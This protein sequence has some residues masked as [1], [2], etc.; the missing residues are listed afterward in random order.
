MEP[1]IVIAIILG[2]LVVAIVIRSRFL[3]IGTP[4]DKLHI[5]DPACEVSD[6]SIRKSVVASAIR[7]SKS[8]SVKDVFFETE[9]VKAVPLGVPEEP[10]PETT[11]ISLGDPRKR[12]PSQLVW[13]GGK[14]EL[15][16]WF[17]VHNFLAEPVKLTD[18]KAH[19]YHVSMYVGDGKMIHAPNSSRSVE[20]ISI[21][22]PSYKKNYSGARRYLMAE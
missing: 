22:S 5:W 13:K 7:S 9:D 2:V 8:T 20:I 4:S 16:V 12:N 21:D 19:V 1:G 18:V 3:K 15:H 17:F 10:C 14:F 6:R 11:L